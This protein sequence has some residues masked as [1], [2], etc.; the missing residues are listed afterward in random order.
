MT[1]KAKNSQQN[2]GVLLGLSSLQ[3]ENRRQAGLDNREVKAPSKSV[4]Q[5]IASN[6]FTYFNL[7]FLIIA[8]LLILVKSYRDLTFLPIIVA[9]TL[10]GIIQELRA[11]QVLDNLNL[12]N[13]P[14]VHVLRDGDLREVAVYELVKDDVVQL[15]AGNQIPADARVV[16]GEVTVNESLL[17]GE[18]DEVKKSLG[19]ILM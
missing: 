11:K 9:N 1:E 14:R 10:I 7:I 6:L 16:E 8:V 19:A 5:I 4:G 18:A 15:G 12:M 3:V 13:M 2:A 17:T